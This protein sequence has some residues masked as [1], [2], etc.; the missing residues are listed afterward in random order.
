[1]RLVAAFVA[2]PWP[3]KSQLVRSLCAVTFVRVALF[4]VGPRTLERL[5][6]RVARRRAD[7]VEVSPEV[8][9]NLVWTVRAAAR[10]VPS[11]TCLTQVIT[12][13]LLLARRGVGSQM[14]IGV[15]RTATGIEAHSWAETVD[16]R[17]LF[18]PGERAQYSPLT[19][20]YQG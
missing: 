3:T 16:G 11:A 9:A 20:P 5:A 2:L 7:C 8:I 4:C 19:G 15:R 18:D 13:Q 14:R 10:A 6:A 12:A 17:M 1:M